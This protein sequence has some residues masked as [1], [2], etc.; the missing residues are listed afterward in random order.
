MKRMG[1]SP[2]TREHGRARANRQRRFVLVVRFSGEHEL[3]RHL[4]AAG[5]HI[6]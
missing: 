5:R 4:T 3:N 1:M 6:P 2:E